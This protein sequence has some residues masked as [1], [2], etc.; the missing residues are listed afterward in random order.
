M[1]LCSKVMSLSLALAIVGCTHL[2]SVSLTQIPANRS[3]KVRAESSKFVFF[4][5]SF[6]NDYADE[7]RDELKGKC[8]NGKI[9]GILTKDEF[10]NYF[11]GIVAKR[12]IVAEGFCDK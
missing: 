10:I 12:R 5:F 2:Q 1:K 11:L 8:K 9:S 3:H 7:V 4:F 6:D